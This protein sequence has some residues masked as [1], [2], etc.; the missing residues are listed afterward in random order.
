MASN[1]N[2]ATWEKA[3][4]D[5]EEHDVWSEKENSKTCLLNTTYT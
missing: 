3:L 2:L 5:C 1:Y 4:L